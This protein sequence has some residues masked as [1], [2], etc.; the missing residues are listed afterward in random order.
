M[1]VGLPIAHSAALNQVL[2]IARKVAPFDT[3]VLIRGETGT[4]KEVVA[5]YIHDR[6]HRADSRLLSLNC[7]ALPE[8]LLESELFGHKAGAFT[9][10]VRDRVGLFEQAARGTILLDEIGDISPAIQ[11]KLLRVLQ[12]REILRIGESLPRRVDTRILAATNRNLDDDVAAGR[13]RKDLLYRLRVVE[14]EVPPLRARVDDIRPLAVHLGQ[15]IAN[16]LRI[17]EVTFDDDVLEIFDRYHWPGNVRELHNAIER[18]LV[19]GG[20][21]RVRS[22]HLPTQLTS[23]SESLG[24]PSIVTMSLKYVEAAHIRRVLEYTDGNRSR[25]AAILGIGQST[26][27]RKLKHL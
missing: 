17:P 1:N 19:L 10:A 12:E 24:S 23:P 16:R 11:V 27:W 14:I 15:Q 3:A 6:S 4:G 26:L 9:G 21:G 5:R 25:A 2:D 8:T 7:G 22:R 20:D 18:A 13:F